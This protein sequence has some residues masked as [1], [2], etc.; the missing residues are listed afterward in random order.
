MSYLHT[1]PLLLCPTFTPLHFSYVLPSHP[2]TAYMSHPSHPDVPISRPS[3]KSLREDL[4]IGSS[5][6][7]LKAR[8]DD[9]SS[10]NRDIVYSIRRGDG[11]GIFT[12]DSWSGEVSCYALAGHLITR[13]VCSKY[14]RSFGDL[15]D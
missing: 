15:F 14:C 7:T 1:P 13:L 11:Q 4:P 6:Y 10:P 3:Q 2:S 8:D 12:I 9:S 5:V